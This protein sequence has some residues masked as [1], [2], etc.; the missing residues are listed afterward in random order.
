MRIK[1]EMSERSS[2]PQGIPQPEKEEYV[3]MCNVWSF[4]ESLMIFIPISMN[5]CDGCIDSTLTR[6]GLMMWD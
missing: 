5:G 2:V 4:G 3:C 1:R 6:E